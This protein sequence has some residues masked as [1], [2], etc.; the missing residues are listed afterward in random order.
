M[1]RSMLCLLPLLPAAALPSQAKE[2]AGFPNA[3]TIYTQFAHAPSSLSVEYMKTELDTI[4]AALDLHF[5]WRALEEANG[6]R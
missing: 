6:H 2:P 5:E 1:K 4:M 3:I